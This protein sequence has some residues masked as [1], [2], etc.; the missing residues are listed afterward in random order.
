M[1]SREALEVE[2]LPLALDLLIQRI[3]ILKKLK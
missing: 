2:V 3:L 1:T